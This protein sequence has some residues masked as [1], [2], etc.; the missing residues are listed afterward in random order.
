MVLSR[1]SG[2]P[3]INHFLLLR[4]R[5]APSQLD[6]IIADYHARCVTVFTAQ[7]GRNRTPFG[8]RGGGQIEQMDGVLDAKTEMLEAD[9]VSRPYL[10]PP[11]D[12]TEAQVTPGIRPPDARL[13]KRDHAVPGHLD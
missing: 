8:K 5:H 10:G 12:V 13:V 2:I 11:E 3:I 6:E 9:G 4:P 1:R 7:M